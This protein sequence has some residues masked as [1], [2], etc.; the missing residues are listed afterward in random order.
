[1]TIADAL[2]E[3]ANVN[4]RLAALQKRILANARIATT[5]EPLE[6]PRP[7]LDEVALLLPRL[8]LLSA[9]I[10]HANYRTRVS[11][12][13]SD[14]DLGSASAAS[15]SVAA[16]SDGAIVGA[17][18]SSRPSKCLLDLVLERDAMAIVG[19]WTKKITE[20][21]AA[22]HGN[23]SNGYGVPAGTT[24]KVLVPYADFLQQQEALERK[25]QVL[26]KRIQ[27]L[28]ACTN[29]VWPSETTQTTITVPP[30]ES[31]LTTVT[32]PT[33]VP[34]PPPHVDD[35]QVLDIDVQ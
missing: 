34:L 22:A 10:A 6:Q 29:I 5:S 9:A 33:T 26:E 17:A 8:H 23:G 19:G 27:Y 32:V 15:A 30:T 1:M 21:V 20:T 18:S 25:R 28:N 14:D 11:D 31:V 7:M 4:R 2:R 12:Q 13:P 16:S 3:K 24:F 35:E